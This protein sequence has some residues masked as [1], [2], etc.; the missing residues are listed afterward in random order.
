MS[1]SG[2]FLLT[3]LPLHL[4]INSLSLCSADLFNDAVHF[5]ETNLLIQVMQ[6]ALGIGFLVHII[7]GIKLE[8]QN[9]KARPIK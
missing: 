4:L 9:R 8:M 1:L 6:P 5:M 2:L 3:F 7:M